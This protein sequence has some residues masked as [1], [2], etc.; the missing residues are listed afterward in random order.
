[1]ALV[2]NF[3]YTFGETKTV[4]GE[5]VLP[6]KSHALID[7]AAHPGFQPPT[8]AARR[9]VQTRRTASAL[10]GGKAIRVAKSAPAENVLRKESR[11]PPS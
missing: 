5:A 6:R 11:E 10:L 3:L 1:M 2:S 7:E 4:A 9:R 8:S